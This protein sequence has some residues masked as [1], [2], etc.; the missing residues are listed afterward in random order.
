MAAALKGVGVPDDVV[1]Q[2][3]SALKADHYLVIV[4]GTADEIDTAFRVLEGTAATRV[5]SH[6]RTTLPT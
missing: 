3:E 6:V 5:D 2:Y 1:P 4:Y